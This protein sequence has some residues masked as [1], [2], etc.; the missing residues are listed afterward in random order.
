MEARRKLLVALHQSLNLH[1]Q[2]A[3]LQERV[4]QPRRVSPRE[5]EPIAVLTSVSDSTV[6][7]VS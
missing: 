5:E 2:L 7:R 1:S 6:R 3:E 4:A